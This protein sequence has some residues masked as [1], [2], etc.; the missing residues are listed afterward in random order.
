MCSFRCFTLQHSEQPSRPFLTIPVMAALSDFIHTGVWRRYDDGT[1]STLILTVTQ[2]TGVLLTATLALFVSLSLG[3]LWSIICFALHQARSTPAPRSGLHHQRQALLRSAP[4][5]GSTAWTLVRLAW[6]WRG[7]SPGVLPAS[8]ALISAAVLF[9]VALAA[10][11][12]LSSRLQLAG[13]DVLVSG[14]CARPLPPTDD[15]DAQEWAFSYAQGLAGRKLFERAA[16][17]VRDCYGSRAASGA[18]PDCGYSPVDK[19]PVTIDFDVPCPFAAEFCSG[20]S[21]MT[22]DSGLVDSNLHLG[23]NSPP[24][25][26]VRFRKVMTCSPIETE[27]FAG[28]WTQMP[29]PNYNTGGQVPGVFYKPFYLGPRGVVTPNPKNG[30]RNYTWVV[31]NS[32]SFASKKLERVEIR[33]YGMELIEI[34]VDEPR[35]LW[36]PLPGLAVSDADL[37]MFV[38]RNDAEYSSAVEDPW[39]R[40]TKQRRPGGGFISNQDS[41]A[42]CC[43]ERYQACNTTACTGLGG[44]LP[45]LKAA[46]SE[47]GLGLNERQKQVFDI[48]DTAKGNQRQYISGGVLRAHDY[49][50]VLSSVSLLSWGLPRD[51]W[52]TEMSNIFNITMALAQLIPTFALE[53]LNVPFVAPGDGGATTHWNL[54]EYVS[55]IRKFQVCG[56]ART[57]NLRHANFAFAPLVAV[58]AVG[59]AL[60]V[61]NLACLPNA[62]FWLQGRLGMNRAY[63]RREWAQGHLFML[64]LEKFRAMGIGPWEVD[65][66]GGGIPWMA[67]REGD[68]VPVLDKFD[69]LSKKADPDGESI[70][71]G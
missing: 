66:E 18:S 41:S 23:I 16:R 33:P 54:G 65:E 21:A 29:P 51:Q 67:V 50:Q 30:Q 59:V 44:W 53:T 60:A 26:R 49:T 19:I 61:V 70:K 38:L 45:V 69:D 5:P 14:A 63:Q 1:Q 17:L 9:I 39:F 8:S 2:G 47:T 32:T 56:L 37:V 10:S 11:S 34:G 46:S 4:S 24:E 57:R 15:V 68:E 71:T 27:K 25:D 31:T 62:A 20:N 7:K 6:T 40:A 3:Q 13:G 48:L 28:P 42:V 55:A 64:Q 36:K 58:L 35:T 22:M 43:T 52:Q 12:L